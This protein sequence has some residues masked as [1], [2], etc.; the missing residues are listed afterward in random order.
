MRKSIAIVGGGTAGWLTAL[1]VRKFYPN[2]KITVIESK[3]IGILGAGEGTTPYFI[4]ILDFLNIPFSELVKHCK[5]T[6]KTGIKFTNWNGDGSY[7]YHGFNPLGDLNWRSCDELFLDNALLIKEAAEK[8]TL[9]GAS[10]TAK[11]AE[12]ARVPFMFKNSVQSKQQNPILHFDNVG[13]FAAHFDARLLAQFFQKYAIGNQFIDYIE[14]DVSH[15]SS[16]G[17]GNITR[18][19]FQTG[20]FMECDFVFDCTGFQRF[21]IGKHFGSEWKSYSDYLPL[22]A[23]VPFFVE[24]D[25]TNIAPHTESIAMKYG[26]MWKIP[27]QGRYGCGYVF[28]TDY[29]NGEQAL[30]EAE[31]YFGHSL[32]SPTS[33]KFEAGTYKDV[34]IKNCMAVGLAGGFIEP[35]EATSIWTSCLNLVSFLKSGGLFNEDEAF[36]KLFNKQCFERNEEVCQFIQFHYLTQRN[37]SEFWGSFRN[38]IKVLDGLQEKLDKW[39]TSVPSENDGL[40][41]LFAIESWLEVGH[42]IGAIPREAFISLE[43]ERNISGRIGNYYQAAIDNQDLVIAGCLTHD[44][45]LNYL[46]N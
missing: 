23:A 30:A 15:A 7:Y 35:L 25:D 12:S 28:D 34:L 19:D 46:R 22:K 4:T 36:K 26:W 21:F 20:A 37:D 33:F 5:A 42:G 6:V 39:Q 31:E 18:L 29:I 9:F 11:M 43:K 44:A 24:H 27:V 17:D 38:K 41:R 3:N 32:K 8:D 1:L 13:A 10:T 14:G 45:L 16:D 40:G 2:H